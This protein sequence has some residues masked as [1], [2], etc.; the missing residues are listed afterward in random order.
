MIGFGTNQGIVPRACEQIFRRIADNTDDSM[1]YQVSFSM[2]EIYNEKVTDLL[3]VD[4]KRMGFTEGLKIREAK[5]G[6]VY[7]QGLSKH[8][9]DSY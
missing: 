2:L 8:P 5:K 9:V 6:D 7:V 4:T 3:A 1:A